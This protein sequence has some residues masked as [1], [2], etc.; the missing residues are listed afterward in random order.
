MIVIGA[1]AAGIA[2]SKMMLNFGVKD[3]VVY[4]SVGAVYRGRAEKMNPYKKQLA[5]IT[6]KQNV[7]G[8]FADGFAGKDIF[9]GVASP[10]MV[11]KE[12]IAKMNKN[13][14]AF[15]L[16]NPIGEISVE[17]ALEAGA[18]IAA[19]GRTINNA[20]AY[21]AL[22]RG[23]LDVRAKAITMEMKIAAAQEI[24][25]LAQNGVLLPDILNKEV[26]RKVTAVVAQ[27]WKG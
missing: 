14:I 11:S 10:N 26:H 19:D 9:V 15:P 2:I 7:K 27:A 18:A 13:A 12:M 6:N 20:L 16:S 21:P 8:A 1:G 25:G 24:A 5:E 22:F 17:E 3:I 4:D 23:A